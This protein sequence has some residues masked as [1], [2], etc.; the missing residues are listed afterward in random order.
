MPCSISWLTS[1]KSPRFPLSPLAHLLTQLHPCDRADSYDGF[2]HLVVRGRGAGGDPDSTS[3]TQPIIA[4]GLGLGPDGLVANHSGGYVD[5]FGVL[6]VK[7]GDAM[8][9]HQCRKMTRVAGVVPTHHD[10]QIER[11]LQQ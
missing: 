7:G 5:G 2:P 11:F 4:A 3:G 6:D 10:H 1:M 9:M 8:L